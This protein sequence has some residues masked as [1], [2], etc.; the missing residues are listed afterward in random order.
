M[1]M[2]DLPTYQLSRLSTKVC[3]HCVHF[4]TSGC[5]SANAQTRREIRRFNWSSLST[6]D[7]WTPNA[8][9]DE[10]LQALTWRKLEGQDID[11]FRDRDDIEPRIED[12]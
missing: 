3:R 12:D 7:A 10:A 1:S 11:D 8:R 2:S 4:R 6:C 9:T 5:P